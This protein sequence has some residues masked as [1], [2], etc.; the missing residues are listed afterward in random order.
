M[1]S[2]E[3]YQVSV[4]FFCLYFGKLSWRITLRDRYKYP[5]LGRNTAC[6]AGL[7]PAF[8]IWCPPVAIAAK[9]CGQSAMPAGPVRWTVHRYNGLVCRYVAF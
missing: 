1:L 6:L 4:R 8:F 2:W 5:G 7:G 9:P 3:Q